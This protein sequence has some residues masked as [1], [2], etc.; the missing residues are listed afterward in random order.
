MIMMIMTIMT[1]IMIMIV[2]MTMMIMTTIIMTI[3]MKMMM[4]MINDYGSVHSAFRSLEIH[5]EDIHSHE[6]LASVI[7]FHHVLAPKNPMS[8]NN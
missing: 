3:I 4:T 2:M 6:A 8:S 7:F 5:V 1:I